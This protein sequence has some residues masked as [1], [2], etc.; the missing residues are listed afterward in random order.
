MGK[1]KDTPK[2]PPILITVSLLS[3]LRRR[4]VVV[5]HTN[6]LRRALNTITRVARGEAYQKKPKVLAK[7]GRHLSALVPYGYWECF[8]PPLS[9]KQLAKILDD[10]DSIVYLRNVERGIIGPMIMADFVSIVEHYKD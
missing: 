5:C 7:V 9:V 6:R 8:D 3:E 10:P 2:P 1:K 4:Q